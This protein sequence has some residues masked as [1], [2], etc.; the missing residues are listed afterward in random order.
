MTTINILSSDEKNMVVD[1]SAARE[2]E[3]I[4]NLMEDLGGAN[5]QIPLPNASSEVLAPIFEFCK[6][7]ADH[8]ELDI[9]K[10]RGT[11]GFDKW[12]EFDRKFCCDRSIKENVNIVNMANYLDIKKLTRLMTIY[13]AKKIQGQDIETIK[14]MFQ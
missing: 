2:S 11:T 9:T 8:P 10:Y 3:V 5:V 13:F 7:H 1:I 14:Q 6:Y 4:C 12:D